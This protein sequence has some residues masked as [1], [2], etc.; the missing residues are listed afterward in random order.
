MDKVKALQSICVTMDNVKA[1][2]KFEGKAKLLNKLSKLY[3]MVDLYYENP[4]Y[5]D[6]C[7]EE[8]NMIF[9]KTMEAISNGK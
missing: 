5:N 8:A 4:T 9:N 2:Q 3:D 6:L 7:V 1:L